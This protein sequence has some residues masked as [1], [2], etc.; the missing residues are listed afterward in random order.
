MKKI[1]LY[2]ILL[3]FF[4]AN[5]FAQT[6]AGGGGFSLAICIDNTLKTWGNNISGQLGNNTFISS[7]IPGPVNFPT[8]II[9]VSAGGEHSL[10]LK[11]DGTLWAFGNNNEGQLG[12]GTRADRHT[13]V[14][15][16][17][18]STDFW[19]VA[20]PRCTNS[21]ATSIMVTW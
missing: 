1:I 11:N 8:G 16:V 19:M 6:I 14:K 13:P 10:A 3:L 17:N 12:D 4:S 2:I 21:S 15:T 9:D 20:L 18:F 5:S 7:N